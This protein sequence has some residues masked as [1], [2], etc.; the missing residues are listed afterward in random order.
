MVDRTVL[1][2]SAL[3]YRDMTVQRKKLLKDALLRLP[4]V[5]EPRNHLIST[6]GPIAALESRLAKVEQF[7]IERH[8]QLGIEQ[9]KQAALSA[10][11]DFWRANPGH[12]D[13]TSDPSRSH[14]Q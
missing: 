5:S 9:E 12:V 1:S 7:G 4:F 14:A 11:S 10:G 13:S 3:A 2:L 8:D 6:S